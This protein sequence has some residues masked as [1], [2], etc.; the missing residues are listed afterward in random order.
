MIR[1]GRKLGNIAHSSSNMEQGPLAS[2]SAANSTVY[3]VEQ[4]IRQ[5][6]ST[7]TRICAVLELTNLPGRRK[8]QVRGTQSESDVQIM[9]VV[10]S[11]SGMFTISC[12]SGGVHKFC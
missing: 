2:V 6:S 11:V 7:C 4:K 8:C 1:T 12:S 5:P 3:V 10:I 9:S